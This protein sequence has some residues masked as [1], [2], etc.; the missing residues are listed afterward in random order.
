MNGYTPGP[1]SRDCMPSRHTLCSSPRSGSVSGWALPE[2]P[3]DDQWLSESNHPSNKK[4]GGKKGSGID[5]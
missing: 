1:R 4:D 3:R 5:K 2:E